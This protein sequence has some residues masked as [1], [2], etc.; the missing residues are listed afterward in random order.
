M[1]LVHNYQKIVT[2]FRQELNKH[3]ETLVMEHPLGYTYYTSNE[4]SRFEEFSSNFYENETALNRC[5]LEVSK[6]KDEINNDYE[7]D[8]SN[9]TGVF[10]AEWTPT[11]SQQSLKRTLILLNGRSLLKEYGKAT[12]V[13]YKICHEENYLILHA[14]RKKD[15]EKMLYLLNRLDS[16]LSQ[17]IS[18]HCEKNLFSIGRF[19]SCELKFSSLNSDVP[20]YKTLFLNPEVRKTTEFSDMLC[21]FMHLSYHDSTTN[22][23]KNLPLCNISE[24]KFVSNG[25][26]PYI[27]NGEKSVT[28]RD[29]DVPANMKDDSPEK[30]KELMISSAYSMNDMAGKSN[31]PQFE[32]SLSFSETKDPSKKVQ[33]SRNSTS[34]I[35][36]HV[37]DTEEKINESDQS[38]GINKLK[39]KPPKF[40]F[41]LPSRPS[42]SYLLAESA[43]DEI[44]VRRVCV[45]ENDEDRNAFSRKRN[46]GTNVCSPPSSSLENLR[47]NNH[48][49][50][51]TDGKVSLVYI[52]SDVC[53]LQ[54]CL[55]AD[56]RPKHLG[57][58]EKLDEQ[59]HK[60][61]QM[62]LSKSLHIL[63]SFSGEIHLSLK[64]GKV[65]YPNVSPEIHHYYQSPS[66][67]YKKDDLPKSLFSNCI[68]NS[69]EEIQNFLKRPVII[70]YSRNEK[71]YD[72]A[73]PKTT[74]T[75]ECFLFHG[76]FKSKKKGQET[77][78]P[79]F[80]K[81][82]S[83]LK[84]RCFF[85]WNEATSVCNLNFVAMPWDARLELHACKVLNNAILKKFSD[86]LC[87][88]ND[89][90]TSIL[91]F[92]NLKN[93]I[94]VLSV[95]RIWENLIP[96]NNE[97]LPHSTDFLLKYSRIN[98]FEVFTTQ[99]IPSSQFVIMDQ[100]HKENFSTFYTVELESPFMNSQ[101]ECNKRIQPKETAK[102]DSTNPQFIGGAMIEN[103]QDW[104]TAAIVTVKQLDNTSL[105]P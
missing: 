71:S 98:D 30:K 49:T 84:E 11:K 74:Q 67:F 91:S 105:V 92:N 32:G 41:K 33:V 12:N 77:S 83:T 75:T 101:F 2:R 8:A 21:F 81:C 28:E 37:N 4:L 44:V 57:N 102:W 86:S 23:Y 39:K 16:L 72:I 24:G 96:F 99:E 46:V 17:E 59:N 22:T 88:R 79:F 90:G 52:E 7:I 47:L 25:N 78:T 18:D 38:S 61:L 85:E 51:G 19:P 62:T 66:R 40:S 3:V 56:S 69:A 94:V 13:K 34:T 14:S 50:T 103:S 93:K 10:I 1:T 68:T 43:S 5:S 76:I 73:K 82:T 27:G 35:H 80:M 100:P 29:S 45:P 26:F 36:P 48:T 20:L 60:L 87:F 6:S 58:Y 53:N 63:Q 89:G 104:Y 64:F 15:L 31:Q 95:Q 42:E 54:L 9:E 70:H 55:Q 97:F 65:I